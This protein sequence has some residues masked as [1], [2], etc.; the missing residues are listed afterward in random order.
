M[1]FVD[2]LVDPLNR[3]A[4]M[5]VNGLG[6]VSHYGRIVEGNVAAGG[7]RRTIVG[8]CT[9]ADVDEP[10]GARNAELTWAVGVRR[11]IEDCCA[12][13]APIGSS[14]AAGQSEGGRIEY[15]AEDQARRRSWRPANAKQNLRGMN[16]ARLKTGERKLDS[17][18]GT[19]R[20]S[21]P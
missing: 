12:C 9:V 21:N 16:A 7:R 4:D 8:R 17:D 11:R 10:S 13:P 1:D 19:G 3:V 14:R 5:H 18:S 20:A 2:G 15:L 6:K